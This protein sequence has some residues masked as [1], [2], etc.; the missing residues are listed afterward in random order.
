MKYNML[1]A[2]MCLLLTCI[3]GCATAPLPPLPD[4]AAALNPEKD[5]PVEGRSGWG[6]RA[7]TV[8]IDGITYLSAYVDPGF[9]MT[10][11]PVVSLRV[12]TAIYQGHRGATYYYRLGKLA[13][14]KYLCTLSIA[15]RTRI[16]ARKSAIRRKAVPN[17]EFADKAAVFRFE[18]RKGS[19]CVRVIT[20]N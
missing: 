6:I 11:E 12:G 7:Q 18:R 14:G 4:Q 13:E 9:E 16:P 17:R 19:R 15:T 3:I 20:L 10:R 1:F 2:L 5:C 8:V